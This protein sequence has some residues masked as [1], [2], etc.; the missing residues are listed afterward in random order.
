MNEHDP[1]RTIDILLRRNLTSIDKLSQACERRI[2]LTTRNTLDTVLAEFQ[3]R[4]ND[5]YEWALMLN[6]GM[7][8]LAMLVVAEP[9]N[10]WDIESVIRG[11]RTHHRFFNQPDNKDPQTRLAD[12]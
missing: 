6:V 8:L 9:N 1:N 7:R 12:N 11:L 10:D 5:V 4:D 3:W 2:Q